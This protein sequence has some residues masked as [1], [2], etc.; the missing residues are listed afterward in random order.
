MTLLDAVQNLTPEIVAR[1]DEIEAARR[2]PADLSRAMARVGVYRMFVPRAYGGTEATPME[3]AQVFEALA[4][5]DASVGWV[6]FIGATSGTVL[7]RIVP[8]VAREIFAD[9]ETMFAGV[10]APTARA[11]H[12]KGAFRVNG[13]WQWGSGTQNA[14]W[15]TGGCL[16]VENG[17]LV[18]TGSG[19]PRQHMLLFRADQ[20]EFLD[21]WH[22]MGLRGTGS[23]D[24]RVT[25][26]VVPETHASG[27]LMR[28]SLPIPLSAFPQFALLALGVAAVAL[29]AA[30]GA[31]DD[32]ITLAATKVRGGAGAPIAGRPHTQTEI[33]LAEGRLRSARAFFYEAIERA[34]EAALKGDAI[35]L[36]LRRDLRLATTHAVMAATQVVDAMY[37]L[38]G[39]T[40]VYADSTLQR[41]FRDVHV[42]T[43]HIMVAPSTLETIGRLMLGLETNVAQF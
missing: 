21:T 32:L 2:V 14:Q 30:R 35:S 39:G 29:G 1:A 7:S 38:A 40:S 25:D 33:A 23:L 22:V 24:Y 28:E 26:A 20:V 34:W 36:E 3:G 9:S 8:D 27:Y 6:A 31:I 41:R 5:A 18:R 37:P 11:E 12:T 19:A 13:R 16:I 4:R 43:Q 15:I 10:F 17:E 42:A